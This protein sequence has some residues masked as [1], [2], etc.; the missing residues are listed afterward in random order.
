MLGN[1]ET[2]GSSCFGCFGDEDQAARFA[3]EPVDE[4]D[5][6]AVHHFV[7]E[8]LFEFIPKCVWASGAGGVNQKIRGFVYNQK[9]VIF[10]NN[11]GT[12]P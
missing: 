9:P 7:S 10:V 8:K 6:A 4:C 2:E 5:L 1:Q 11:T 3:I 12:N